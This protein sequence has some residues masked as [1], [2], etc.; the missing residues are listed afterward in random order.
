ME[1]KLD[2]KVVVSA[3]VREL[4][5]GYESALEKALQAEPDAVVAE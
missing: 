4:Q 2:G 5:E 1:I 3:A